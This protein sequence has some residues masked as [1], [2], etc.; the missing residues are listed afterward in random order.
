MAQLNTYAAWVLTLAIVISLVY[1][2]YRVFFRTGESKYDSITHFLKQDIPLYVSA[3]VVIALLHFSVS[4]AGE[5]AV[6]YCIGLILVGGFYYN[7]YIMPAR[8]PGLID[9]LEN[10]FYSGLLFATV[11]LLGLHFV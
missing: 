5:V 7:P 10:L 9:W 11:T 1:E 4:W 8:N 3:A 6:V 2:I